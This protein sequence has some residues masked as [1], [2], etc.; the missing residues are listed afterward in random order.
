VV[1]APEPR[2][3]LL[4]RFGIGLREPLDRLRHLH[5]GQLI[6]RHREPDLEHVA[7][8]TVEQQPARR[9][10]VG[11]AILQLLRILHL[12]EPGRHFL[13]G[14]IALRPLG[15]LGVIGPRQR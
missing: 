5:V 9:L 10:E 6:G 12:L 7:A 15:E 2:D 3:D 13:R 11:A 8:E 1:E 14:Q 4:A